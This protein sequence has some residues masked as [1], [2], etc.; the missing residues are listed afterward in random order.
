MTIVD[1]QMAQIV[2]Y[3]IQIIITIE[4]ANPT[5]RYPPNIKFYKRDF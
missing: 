1:S 2:N 4:L 3:Q 5:N